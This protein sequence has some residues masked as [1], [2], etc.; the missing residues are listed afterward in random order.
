MVFCDVIYIITYRCLHWRHWK[1]FSWTVNYI[2]QWKAISFSLIYHTQC[3]YSLYN[4]P[5]HYRNIILVNWSGRDE[6]RVLLIGERRNAHKIL[7]GKT[8]S[9]VLILTCFFQELYCE[10]RCSELSSL[11]LQRRHIEHGDEIL[12]SINGCEFLAEWAKHYTPKRNA[13]TPKY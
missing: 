5:T 10:G 13:A 1:F 11:R 6:G 8:E 3:I 9:S 12:G 4:L 7:M 2:F